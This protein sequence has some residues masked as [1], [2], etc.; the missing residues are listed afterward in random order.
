MVNNAKHKWH[1]TLFVAFKFNKFGFDFFLFFYESADQAATKTNWNQAWQIVEEQ[2][3][4]KFSVF[5]QL[6][7]RLIILMFLAIPASEKHITIWMCDEN[8]FQAYE[9]DAWIFTRSAGWNFKF[10]ARGREKMLM[11]KAFPEYFSSASHILPFTA[12]TA[13]QRWLHKFSQTFFLLLL[14]YSFKRG[15]H[16]KSKWSCLGKNV[17]GWWIMGNILTPKANINWSGGKNY[18]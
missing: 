8:N 13:E 11:E 12:H 7:S 15:L 16:L 18:N 14:V 9:C 6:V 3:K 2:R 17:H 10:M 5:T 1:F 4:L